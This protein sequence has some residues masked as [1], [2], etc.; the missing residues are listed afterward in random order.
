[1]S[2]IHALSLMDTDF[3]QRRKIMLLDLTETL[4][5]ELQFTLDSRKQIVEGFRLQREAL[6]ANE[7]QTLEAFDGRMRALSEA[8]GN[9]A[10]SPETIDHI[11]Q[12][13]AGKKQAKIEDKTDDV[14]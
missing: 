12:R 8:I 10:P 11:E 9:G 3:E 13:P 1:M 6:E 14:E 7:R 4:R 5:R 2:S